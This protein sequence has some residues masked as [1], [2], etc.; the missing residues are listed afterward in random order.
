[1]TRF[2]SYCLF[3]FLAA[4]CADRRQPALERREAAVAAREARVA[5]REQELEQKL[6]SFM[7]EQQFHD[8]LKMLPPS[9]IATDTSVNGSWTVQMRCIETTCAGSAIGDLKTEAWSIVTRGNQAIATARV[10]DK[11]VRIYEGTYSVNGW[12]LIAQHSPQHAATASVIRVRLE[13]AGKN[14]LSGTREISRPA[15]ACRVVYQM[16]L[17]RIMP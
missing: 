1:M 4:G 2:L 12:E 10:D 17:N 16:D 8:S 13:A 7:E 3:L 15:E 5:E 9:A 6:Q 14:R 11:I